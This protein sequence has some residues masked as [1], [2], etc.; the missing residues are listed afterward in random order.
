MEE[1]IRSTYGNGGVIIGFMIFIYFITKITPIFKDL[2]LFIINWFNLDNNKRIKSLSDNLNN[3]KKE[4][5]NKLRELLEYEIDSLIY[6]N[7]TGYSWNRDKQL[8][9]L[10]FYNKVKH[11]ICLKRFKVLYNNCNINK[12]KIVSINITFNS[13][14]D[15]FFKY[16]LTVISFLLFIWTFI[17]SI[18]Y[19]NIEFNQKLILFLITIGSFI[20]GFIFISLANRDRWFFKMIKEKYDNFEI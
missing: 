13:K 3:I 12:D 14:S 7:L 4:D 15:L 18:K 10:E 1:I 8:F 20:S 9:F 6:T 17:L 19:Y 2:R 16:F 5:N 11:E